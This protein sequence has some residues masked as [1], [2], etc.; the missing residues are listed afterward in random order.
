MAVQALSSA[1]QE[2]GNAI[3]ASQLADWRRQLI[4]LLDVLDQTD[5]APEREGL[6]ER[7]SRL[8]RGGTIPREIVAM[9]RT[10]TEMRN[11][12]EYQSKTL[13]TAESSAVKAAWF[14]IQEW[15]EARGINSLA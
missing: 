3:S 8:Q 14:A 4:R 9:M 10:I 15:A 7:I 1:R 5:K 12:T 2:S 6:V 13:S 11:A